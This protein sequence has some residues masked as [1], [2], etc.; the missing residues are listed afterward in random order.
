[1]SA[2]KLNT[3]YMAKTRTQRY[4]QAEQKE[5]AKKQNLSHTLN[6]KQDTLIIKYTKE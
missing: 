4:I 3:L 1:M 6:Q 2:T 5:A